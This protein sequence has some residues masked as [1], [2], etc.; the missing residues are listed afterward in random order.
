MKSCIYKTLPAL[1]PTNVC[2]YNYS[3]NIHSFIDCA[4]ISYLITVPKLDAQGA[5]KLREKGKISLEKNKCTKVKLYL[6]AYKYM[7]KE[8]DY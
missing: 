3:N 5:M 8:R 2:C 1:C 6:K 4:H 7:P